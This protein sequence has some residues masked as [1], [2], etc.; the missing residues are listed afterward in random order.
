MFRAS[1]RTN[2]LT[3]FDLPVGRVVRRGSRVGACGVQSSRRHG[4]REAHEVS[5]N[6]P[7]RTVL[8]DACWRCACADAATCREILKPIVPFIRF[9]IMTMED[10][11][12]SVSLRLTC[13]RFCCVL[14][15]AELGF[16]TWRAGATERAR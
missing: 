8:T 7:W 5:T 16:V 15:A 2:I 14:T 13:S 9:P 3:W 6:Q 4:R 11:A 1:L 12:S 10:I